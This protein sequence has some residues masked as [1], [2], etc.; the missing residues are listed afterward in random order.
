ML[1]HTYGYAVIMGRLLRTGFPWHHDN[2]LM[3]GRAGLQIRA[4]SKYTYKANYHA[5]LALT[6]TRKPV[7][8]FHIIQLIPF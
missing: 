2:Q 4:G 3:L 8:Y 5:C 6:I 7:Q 1:S